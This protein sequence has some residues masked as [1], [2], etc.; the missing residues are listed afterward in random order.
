[1]QQAAGI[2]TVTQTR[3]QCR[4]IHAD[5]RPCGS[6]ALR[7]EQF[8]YFHH[9]TRRPKPAPGKFR[10]LDAH[11]PFELPAIEDRTSALAVAAH[12]LSR[13]ASNDLD[14]TRAGRML[15]NLNLIISLLPKE[16]GPAAEGAPAAPDLS[17]LAVSDIVDDET[18]GLIAPLAEYAEPTPLPLALPSP[19]YAEHPQPRPDRVHTRST[20]K[21]LPA[22]ILRPKREGRGR[23]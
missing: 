1:M 10:H 16:P 12:L 11:E 14:A 17:P 19:L 3:I 5:G 20:P 9:T 23:G 22:P 6:P 13:I 18:L 4:H 2:V 15:Y 8:C 7:R 21:P